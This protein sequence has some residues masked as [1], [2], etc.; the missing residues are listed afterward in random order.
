EAEL[1]ADECVDR[2]VDAGA[3]AETDATTEVDVDGGG[4]GV[5]REVV[6]DV[7][8]EGETAGTDVVV[9]GVHA[10]SQARRDAGYTEV[11]GRTGVADAEARPVAALCE[12]GAGTER[13]H[14]DQ[15][16]QELAHAKAS[17][18]T[19]EVFSSSP[20]FLYHG[21]K[22]ATSRGFHTIAMV[23]VFFA[24]RS[25]S[26]PLEAEPLDETPLRV[27]LKRFRRVARWYLTMMP[28]PVLLQEA[29]LLGLR[30]PA[31]RVPPV[32]GHVPDGARSRQVL[33]DPVGHV[34]C[35]LSDV[36]DD[37]VLVRQLVDAGH[38]VASAWRGQQLEATPPCRYG[39]GK[40]VLRRI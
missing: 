8:A 18:R 23:I 37:L 29:R 26:L 22:C 1:A 13:G 4:A 28:P 12:R 17:K 27:A 20:E 3:Y 35:R 7:S 15:R 38:G 31:V 19:R 10:G 34:A 11:E 5:D 14:G 30:H 33:P 21:L 32:P 2:D 25:A 39:H 16:N 9:A 36:D 40:R 6:E 24:C